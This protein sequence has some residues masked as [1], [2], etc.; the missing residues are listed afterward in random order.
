MDYNFK[1]KIKNNK[2]VIVIL[3]KANEYRAA[4]RLKNRIDSRYP[5]GINSL[6]IVSQTLPYSKLTT[7]NANIFYMFPAPK[8]TI[9]KAV[10]YA[11]TKKA[12][13]FAYDEQDLHYGV[14]VSLNIAKKIKPVLNLK[15]IKK[16]NIE[17]RPVLI[18]ISHIFLANKELSMHRVY[19]NSAVEPLKRG[20]LV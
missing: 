2:L 5:E 13:T 15:A 7:S 3:Y 17:M 1:E 10:A 14:M 4:E 18:N 19:K 16:S 11:Y 9:L 8:E 6:T 20:V 12:L